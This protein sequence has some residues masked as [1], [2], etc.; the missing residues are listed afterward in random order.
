[1]KQYFSFNPH[2]HDFW[3]VY[4]AIRTYYLLG[5]R[6]SHEMHLYYEYEGQKKLGKLLVDN[7]HNAE[8]FKERFVNFSDQ[9]QSQFGLEVQG[10]TYGQQPAFSFDLILEK[11]EYPGLIKI[12]KLCLGIS[13]LGDFYSLYGIDET[14]IIEERKPYRYQYYS[15]NAITVSPYAE[16]EQPYLA[17][18]KAV[19]ERYPNH[20]QVPFTIL[21]SYL[22]GLYN[23][24]E[25]TDE[26]MV[27]NAL[28]DQK[29]TNNYRLQ[30]R[31]D[32]Y[33]AYDEWFK[34]GFDPSQFKSVE[35]IVVPPPPIP[36]PAV[37]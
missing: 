35:V 15:I 29:L 23:K 16:F 6:L 8:N 36:P 33:Y 27:Y 13:L 3:P 25:E 31:G 17:L 19:Q 34:E 10:T 26:C 37:I 32:Q 9:I 18:K 20:K 5:I 4:N 11:T 24:Y 7:I 14:I 1:M 30:Q 22:N 28:F 2:S 21:T 12:K